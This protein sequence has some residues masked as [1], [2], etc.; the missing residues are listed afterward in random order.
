MGEWRSVEDWRCLA[1]SSTDHV[2]GPA[3]RLQHRLV[4]TLVDLGSEPRDMDVDDV[5]LRVEMI[6]PDILEQHRAGD[7]VAGIAHQIFKQ[8]EFARLERDRLAGAADGAGQ[9]V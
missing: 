1:V 8:L 5:G 2:S 9:E 7:D 3:D 4:E 6:V